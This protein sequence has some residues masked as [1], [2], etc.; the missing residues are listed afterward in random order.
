MDVFLSLVALV[1]IIIVVWWALRRSAGESAKDAPAGHDHDEH[2]V[3]HGDHE[4]HAD[5]FHEEAAVAAPARVEEVLLHATI[6]NVDVI[7]PQA[8]VKPD[9]LILIEGIGPRISGVLKEKGVSTFAQ[10]AAMQPEE[11]KTLLSSVDERLARIADPGTWPQQAALAANGDL[12]GLQKLQDSLK[13][14]RAA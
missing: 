14:G 10:L 8:E 4:E 6:S 13:A 3:V 11:I 5:A 1:I 7:E 12:E 2:D 9:D